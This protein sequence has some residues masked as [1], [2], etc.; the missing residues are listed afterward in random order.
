MEGGSY[1]RHFQRWRAIGTRSLS[2]RDSIKGTW[3]GE[4][5]TGDL[6]RYVKALKMGLCFHGDTLLGNME[7]RSFLGVLREREREKKYLEEFFRV[8]RDMQKYPV[9]RYLSPYGPCWGKWRGFVYQEFL[10]E[11]K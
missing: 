1:T 5:F 9:N 4:S 3:R 10:R 8:S 2:W 11:K 7:G 6:E